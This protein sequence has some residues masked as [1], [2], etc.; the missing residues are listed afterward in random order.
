MITISPISGGAGGYYID[1][2]SEDYYLKGGEPAGLWIGEGAEDLGLSGTVLRQPFSQLLHGFSPDGRPM[3]KNVGHSD[4]VAGHDITF[5]APKSVSV[6]WSQA[7]EETRAAIQ[8]AQ[9]RAVEKALSYLQ[10]ECAFSRVGQGGREQVKARLVVSTFEHSTSRDQDC[11]LHTHA[12][13]FNACT[14]AD[15]TTGTIL[16]RPF[17]QSQK[18][19]DALY[20]AELAAELQTLGFTIRQTKHGFEVQGVPEQVCDAFSQRRATILAALKEQG[21]WSAKAAEIANLSTRQVKSHLARGLLFDYWQERGRG[22]GF[23][24]TE[25]EALQNSGPLFVRYWET[26]KQAVLERVVTSLNQERSH[27][28]ERDF[29]ERLALYGL[30]IKGFDAETARV[31]TREFL[32]ASKQTISLG[33]V[34]GVIHYTTKEMM[35]LETEM[36]TLIEASK[37]NSRHIL[38]NASVMGAARTAEVEAN[39]TLNGEQLT[40]LRQITRNNGSLQTIAGMAGTGK[41]TLL[42]AARLA[43]E[44]EGYTVLGAAI[45][46]KAAKNLE[47]A[48]GIESRTIAKTLADIDRRVTLKTFHGKQFRSIDAMAVYAS[49]VAQSRLKIDA[50]T[51]LV[52]DEAGMVDS[53][54]M[55]TLL[56]RVIAKGGKVV[57]VGDALQ[58]QPVGVGGPFRRI[59]EEV[60]T[61]ELTTIVRQRKEW[62][63]NATK[64]FARGEAKA[65]LMAYAFEGLVHVARNRNYAATALINDW[66]ERGME[67]PEKTLIIAGTNHEVE[68]LNQKAQAERMQAGKLETTRALRSGDT[69]Y[70]GNDRVI[71]TQPSAPLD[72]RN[73]EMGTVFGIDELRSCLIVKMDDGGAMKVVPLQVY[74]GVKLGYAVTTHRAQG[75]TIDYSYLLVGGRMNNLHQSYVQA[76]RAREEARFYTDRANAGQELETLSAQMNRMQQKDL[77]LDVQAEAVRQKNIQSQAQEQARGQ[78]L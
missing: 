57:L 10:D 69:T 9:Q 54:N 60:G 76:S 64:D 12:L 7:G 39:I 48:T 20:K 13:I 63:Q 37:A 41:S 55:K 19:L 25:V 1:L 3:V 11:Q 40:A 49:K 78:S 42:K 72:L 75:A 74:D 50:K 52:V 43:W 46:G 18:V 77:A 5:S 33:Q 22:L 73:G 28:T 35:A 29:L 59:T 31:A 66:K 38:T 36:L 62:Q 27:F 45:G 44:A 16:S 70:Y 30:G 26:E 8:A 34:N 23:S 17:Y 51:I 68:S 61:A 21:E 56:E 71:F 4:R 65:G 24:R 32:A 14:R 67:T 15:R 58:L 53:R 2:A 47:T 6:V